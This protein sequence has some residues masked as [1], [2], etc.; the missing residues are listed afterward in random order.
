MRSRFAGTTNREVRSECIQ[1]DQRLLG[2]LQLTSGSI[3]RNQIYYGNQSN[4]FKL[5]ERLHS[6][7]PS[8][9]WRRWT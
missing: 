8:V 5:M 3:S 6:P 2:Q 1:F 4:L 7:M 9:Y